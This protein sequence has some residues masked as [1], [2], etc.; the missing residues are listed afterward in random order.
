[1]QITLIQMGGYIPENMQD[2]LWAMVGYAPCLKNLIMTIAIKEDQVTADREVT[3]L[4]H[5]GCH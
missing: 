5:E 1:M 2:F 3:F 4:F